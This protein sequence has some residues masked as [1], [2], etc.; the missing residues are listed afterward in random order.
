[1][2]K[3]NELKNAERLAKLVRIGERDKRS[4]DLQTRSAG[5]DLVETALDYFKWD[6]RDGSNYL[7]RLANSFGIA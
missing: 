4:R 6:Q 1:M 7:E 3:S 5:E 2:G